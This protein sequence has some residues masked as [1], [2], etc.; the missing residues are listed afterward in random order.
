MRYT[1]GLRGRECKR[2]YSVS[3]IHVCEFHF[4]PIEA[5]YDSEM[6]GIVK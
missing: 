2:E 1:A 6:R 4:G 3:P 5:I